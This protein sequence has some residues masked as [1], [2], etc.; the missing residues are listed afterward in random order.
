VATELVPL[1]RNQLDSGR[2][3]ERLAGGELVARW[4]WSLRFPVNT[5]LPR[6]ATQL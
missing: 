6:H 1:E 4:S 2:D 3:G 5:D